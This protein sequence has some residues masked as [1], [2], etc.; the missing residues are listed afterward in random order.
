MLVKII[1]NQLL[2]LVTGTKEKEIGKADINDKG[3][4]LKPV[5]TE[6]VLGF[7]VPKVKDSTGYWRWCC[8]CGNISVCRT[9]KSEGTILSRTSYG[10][11]KK[12]QVPTVETTLIQSTPTTFTQQT[13][14]DI[15]NRH[16]KI[17]NNQK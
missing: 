15:H 5:I 1:R 7:V 6:T 13:T 8:S 3:Q 10:N 17:I 9:I 4:I 14:Q 2:L 11:C 16:N 12:Y